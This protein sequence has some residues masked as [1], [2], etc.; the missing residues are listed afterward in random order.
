MLKN[1]H[2][3][4]LITG[5]IALKKAKFVFQISKKLNEVNTV[6]PSIEDFVGHGN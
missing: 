3:E 6:N 2:C 4:N 1:Q 5:T